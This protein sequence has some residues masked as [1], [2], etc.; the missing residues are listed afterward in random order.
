MF[1]RYYQTELAY[2]R[3]LAYE[4]AEA[5]PEVAHLVSERQGDVA[6]ERLLQGSAMLT[7]RLRQRLD[8]ALPEIAHPLFEVLWPQFLRPLPACA[9]IQC[10]PAGLQRSQRIERGSLLHGR[11]RGDGAKGASKADDCAFRTCAPVDVHPLVIEEIS[12]DRPRPSDLQLRLRL[13]LTEGATLGNTRLSPLRLQLC[14]EGE[15]KY[16]IFLWLAHHARR[17]TV[18]DARGKEALALPATAIRRCGLSAEE[19]LFPFARAPLPGLRVLQEYFLLAEKLLAV[20]IDGLEALSAQNPDSV[21]EELTLIFHLGAIAEGAVRPTVDSIQLGCTAAINLSESRRIE[22]EGSRETSTFPL[23]DPENGE[24]FSIE[25]VG[26]YCGPQGAWIDFK[27]LLARLRQRDD[28]PR[29]WLQRHAGGLR[30]NESYLA[31]TDADG[32]PL[33]PNTRLVVWA[34]C[35]DGNRVL[36]LGAGD[37]NTAGR[38]TPQLVR[39]AN[40]T[41]VRPSVPPPIAGERCWELLAAFAMPTEA[42]LSLE[43][44]QQLVGLAQPKPDDLPLQMI[45]AVSS[46]A[47]ERLDRRM[48]VPMR[49]V[50][51]TLDLQAFAGLG[52]LFLFG[53]LLHRVF[54]DRGGDRS[55]C[56]LTVRSEPGGEVFRFTSHDQDHPQPDAPP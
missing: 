24:I 21:D 49:Q 27:P 40:V 1:V 22:L 23:E 47:A 6:V 34:T 45:R 43:G 53:S 31:I 46:T 26:G 56:E 17:V 52:D 12:L 51:V 11:P 4:F 30:A 42:L 33:A 41:P 44:L 50:E 25:R 39:F 48:M 20:E 8:D 35:V 3:E 29:F 7:A 5:Y 9:L 55:H 38:G 15:E 10:S 36:E 13:A 14:G 16:Q 19:A 54:V 37:I 28:T 2:L 18:L 32:N